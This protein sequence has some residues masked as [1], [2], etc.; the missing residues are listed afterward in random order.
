MNRIKLG[1]IDKFNF[2]SGY[3]MLKYSLFMVY[4]TPKLVNI[5]A[6]L[7]DSHREKLTV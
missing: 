7:P 6:A 4:K 2:S 3:K 1:Q 5:I